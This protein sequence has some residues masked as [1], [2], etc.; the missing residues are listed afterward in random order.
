[1]P[2]CVSAACR[3]ANAGCSTAQGVREHGAEG[4][5]GGRESQGASDGSYRHAHGDT[6]SVAQWSKGGLGIWGG[7]GV[8]VA[9]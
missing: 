2:A 3:S 6:V 5:Q 7:V 9:A 4:E 1:M 8:A